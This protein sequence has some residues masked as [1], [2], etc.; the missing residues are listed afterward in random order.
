MV[1]VI[2]VSMS[3]GAYKHWH[4]HT[5]IWRVHMGM[6]MWLHGCMRLNS[7]GTLID[8]H[9]CNGLGWYKT[10]IVLSTLA[11]GIDVL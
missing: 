10:N 5:C 11:R 3:W 6:G 8:M 7:S 1:E 9:G 4:E 2:V